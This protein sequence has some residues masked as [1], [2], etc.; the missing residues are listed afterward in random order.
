M[1]SYRFTM[2]CHPDLMRTKANDGGICQN[3]DEDL[4]LEHMVSSW[5]FKRFC[6]TNQ[7]PRQS[8]EDFIKDHLSCAVILKTSNIWHC[9]LQRIKQVT[10]CD[11]GNFLPRSRW[12]GSGPARWWSGTCEPGRSHAWREPADTSRTREENRAAI[13]SGGRSKHPAHSLTSAEQTQHKHDQ[14]RTNTEK[15]S[16]DILGYNVMWS[17]KIWTDL[18]DVI[19]HNKWTMKLLLF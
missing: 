11:G 2:T 12:M 14:R 9:I 16:Q 6:Q 13:L 19:H 8:M 1:C 15:F 17:M 5:D 18:G 10:E 3:S 4:W 7:A